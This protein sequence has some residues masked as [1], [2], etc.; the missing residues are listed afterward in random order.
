M[1]VLLGQLEIAKNPKGMLVAFLDFSK[2]Y[3]KVD[4]KKLWTRLHDMG[5]NEPF[6]K[7]LKALY[8]G[9]SCRVQVED[10]LSEAFTINTGLRQGCVLSPTLFS[11]YMNDVVT[12]LKE[13]GYGLQCGSDTIPGLLFADDTALLAHD[14]DSLRKSLNCLAEWCE[15]WGVGINVSKCGIMHMRKKGA[16]RSK[17]SYSIGGEDLPLVSNYKYL[18]C[19][20]DE[21]LDLDDMVKDKGVDGKKALGA[22]FQRCNVEMGGVE[23]RTFKRL[24]S[25]IVESTMMYGAEVWG[26]N[27]NVETLQQVQ[28]KAARLFFGVGTRHPRVSLLW[29][30]GHLLVVWIAKL[31]CVTF[32]FKVLTSPMYDKRLLRRVAIESVRHGKGSWMKKMARCC[33]DFDWENV[34][35]MHTQNL[36]ETELRGML[37]SIAWRKV[38]EKWREEL[39][40]KPKLSTMQTI[41][42]ECGEE[43]RCA[44]IKMKNER[45]MILKLRG[46]TAPLQVE[47]GRWRGVK[48]E[49][50]TCKECNSGEVEDVIHW[51][52]RCLTWNSQRQP[53][54][55][56]IQP[57][58]DDAI[59][60][61]R[62]LTQA[63]HN[64]QLI[65]QLSIIWKANLDTYNY[66]HV[67]VIM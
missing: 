67:C 30:L 12:T 1:L 48:R 38:Q 65:A 49:E 54:M 32:W 29:E 15:E 3:D 40:R 52:L 20:V 27:R 28:L 37:E 34:G 2:A 24:M 58:Q 59:T 4:R 62:I 39:E 42:M 46:G 7:S 11:L 8:K 44:G 22:W 17:M 47:M 60:T 33:Q 21:H 50:R 18:G 25:S 10:R 31:R 55:K 41:I 36:S 53:L 43:S 6:L 61:A 13:K 51:L 9:S 57:S 23:V 63:C 35:Q 16:V 14:E 64:H 56:M 19:T 5:I 45:R 66:C 26:C